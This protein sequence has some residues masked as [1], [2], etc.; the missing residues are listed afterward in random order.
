MPMYEY[1]ATTPEGKVFEGQR[2]EIDHSAMIN[3]LQSSGYIPIYAKEAKS[4]SNQSLKK[5]FA[6]SK[7][8]INSNQLLAFT[9]QLATLVKAKLPVDHALRIFRDLS[10]HENVRKMSASLL[11]DVEAGSD[12]SSALEKQKTIFSPY[13]IN[14]VR[15]SEAS[16]NLEIGLTRM[17]EYLESAKTMRDKLISSLIYPIILMVVAMASIIVIMTFVVPKITELFEGSEELLPVA[18]KMVIS[19]SNFI[20]SY[21]WLLLVI[22]IFLGFLIRYVFTSPSYRK[23]WDA[24]LVK[25]PVFGDLLVKHET[26]KFTSSLGSLLSNGVPVLSALPIAKANLTNSL[27][28]DNI[29]RAM[30]QFKE[31]K[32]L[33]HTLSMAKLFPS[34]ALQM[35]KVG[36][37]TGELDNMLKRVSEIYEK[38]TSNAMQRLVNL[39]E[40]AIIILLGVVIGGII[41]SILVGMVSINDLAS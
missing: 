2:E 18:T 23:F 31:G 34:L 21:W 1:K 10:E 14:M 5:V 36:E 32:S 30:E 20:S 8:S 40:P 24:K 22:F 33:F 39:F 35:I 41:V 26:A 13:Y 11:E 27:F 29:S 19:V 16:G 38:E 15:A 25:L 7:K 12:L 6:V 37:E 17:H 3:W 28:L 4:Y 9:E